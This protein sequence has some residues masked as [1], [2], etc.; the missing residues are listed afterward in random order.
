[1]FKTLQKTVTTAG[2]V[3]SA[4]ATS[5]PTRGTPTIIK[6]LAGNQG[7]I[8]VGATAADALNSSGLNFPLL[9]GESIA[10]CV[11]DLQEIFLDATVNGEGVA[12]CFEN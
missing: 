4:V 10:I 5:T 1:M 6:A 8:T 11:K 7:T 12:I 3:V 2:T 9:A